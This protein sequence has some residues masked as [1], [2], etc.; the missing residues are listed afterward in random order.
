MNF[1]NLENRLDFV[2]QP[3]SQPASKPN[4][5]PSCARCTASEIQHSKG[6]P[7]R[8]TKLLFRT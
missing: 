5:R 7:V 4:V 3:A 8:F 6:N 1:E 2:C